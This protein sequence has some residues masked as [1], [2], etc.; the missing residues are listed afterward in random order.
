M[1]TTPLARTQPLFFLDKEK[2]KGSS[3]E[4]Q[5]QD[6]DSDS[7]QD[8]DPNCL[9]EDEEG[10]DE[11]S[12]AK[13]ASANVGRMEIGAGTKTNGNHHSECEESSE[14]EELEENDKEQVTVQVLKNVPVSSTPQCQTLS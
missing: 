9:V 14:E 4:R 3:D 7:G 5:D 10:V 12:A 1:D 8:E 11:I 13:K 2:E 6:S